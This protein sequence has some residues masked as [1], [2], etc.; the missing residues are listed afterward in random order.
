MAETIIH[1]STLSYFFRLLG[2]VNAVGADASAAGVKS[3]QLDEVIAKGN[4][5]AGILTAFG[6]LTG[7]VAVGLPATVTPLPAV[8]VPTMGTVTLGPNSPG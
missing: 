1:H 5:A 2:F 6:E 4:A 3:P 8:E 7:S